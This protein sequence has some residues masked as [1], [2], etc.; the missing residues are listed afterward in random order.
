MRLED[1]RHRNTDM[2]WE[3]TKYQLEKRYGPLTMS[4]SLHNLK[5]TT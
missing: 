4:A 1:Q 2:P 5:N 3:V